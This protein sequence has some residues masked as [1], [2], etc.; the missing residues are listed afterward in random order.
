MCSISRFFILFFQM[1]REEV[2]R[3]SWK[4]DDIEENIEALDAKIEEKI[5]YLAYQEI[6][7]CELENNKEKLRTATKRMELMEMVCKPISDHLL[8]GDLLWLSLHT[9]M[10]R[11]KFI[12]QNISTA[13]YEEENKR[14]AENLVCEFVNEMTFV[15]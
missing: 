1:F 15:R 7:L 5:C 13:Q 9:E 12:L 14:C 6:K 4:T 8:L 10:E 11:M 3:L 2:E